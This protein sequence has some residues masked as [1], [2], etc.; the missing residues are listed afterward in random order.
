[1]HLMDLHV[2]CLT[3]VQDILC[4][5][6]PINSIMFID[7]C[8]HTQ[9]ILKRPCILGIRSEWTAQQLFFVRLR[10]GRDGFLYSGSISRDVSA[11]MY[12][13]SSESLQE[14]TV[15]T[16]PMLKDGIA[17]SK[18]NSVVSDT[19]FLLFRPCHHDRARDLI[20]RLRTNGALLKH[21]GASLYTVCYNAFELR[22]ESRLFCN[23]DATPHRDNNDYTTW[24]EVRLHKLI[25]ARCVQVQ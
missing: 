7:C 17:L 12:D 20:S 16:L 18:S 22:F 25:G 5:E 21:S 8:K 24:M 3:A 1:M 14:F 15:K 2:D 4:L 19:E 11:V 10:C 9:G 6:C 13:R 23:N